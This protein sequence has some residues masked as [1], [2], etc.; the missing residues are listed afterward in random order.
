MNDAMWAGTVAI[1]GHGDAEL[2]AYLARPLSDAPRGGVV[3]IHHL[4]GYDSGTREFARTFAAHGY[5]A[6]VPN[7]YSRE[8]ADVAPDDQAAA[9]R[10]KG[11]VPDGQLVGDVAGAAAYLNGLEHANGKVGVI[12]HCSGGRHAFLAACSLDLD[13]AVDCYGAF[14][15][16]DP[17]AD[18]PL[19]MTSLLSKAPDLSCPLLGLFGED[20]EFPAPDEVAALDAELTK[21]G[22]EHE[23][24]SYPGAGHAFFAVERPSFRPAAAKD[25]WAKIFAFYG[26]HLSA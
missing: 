26:R 14:V 1:T 25:G 18:S 9:V 16:N 7:L 21:L 23:F 11:G 2:E 19:K 4:P 6:I 24:H 13:A 5:A 17:P 10:A 20:D 22:K 3:V 8:G 15:V 12:G